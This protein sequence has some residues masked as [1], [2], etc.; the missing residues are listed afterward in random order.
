MK[1]RVLTSHIQPRFPYD[2]LRYDCCWPATT[3]DAV[4]LADPE[5]YEVITLS[6][7]LPEITAKRWESFGWQVKV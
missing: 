1:F 5:P 3:E 6:T 2:M 4:R 7:N